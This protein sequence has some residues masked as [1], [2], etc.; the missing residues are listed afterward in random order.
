MDNKR[1][2]NFFLAAHFTVSEKESHNCY[3]VKSC[4]THSTQHPPVFN[5]QQHKR[6]LTVSPVEFGEARRVT[7]GQMGGA[8]EGR[9]RQIGHQRAVTHLCQPIT[10][11]KKS[12]EFRTL[13]IHFL[14]LQIKVRVR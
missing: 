5:S 3:R 1:K 7:A 11:Q 14:K 13:K 10:K 12:T 4:P 2:Q 9:R 6:F 8:P